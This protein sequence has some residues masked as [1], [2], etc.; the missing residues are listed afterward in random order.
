MYQCAE[1]TE[2]RYLETVLITLQLVFIHCE[3]GICRGQNLLYGSESIENST[4]QYGENEMLNGLNDIS[5]FLKF[6]FVLFY[7]LLFFTTNLGLYENP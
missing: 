1:S 7:Y 6:S 3:N 2:N 5:P 4:F